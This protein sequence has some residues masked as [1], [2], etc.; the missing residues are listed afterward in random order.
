M[1]RRQYYRPLGL[2]LLVVQIWMASAAAACHNHAD[3]ERSPGAAGA[4]LSAPFPGASLS[5]AHTAPPCAACTYLKAVRGA[6]TVPAFVPAL[7]SGIA[8]V[9]PSAGQRVLYFEAFH[10]FIPNAQTFVTLDQ[11]VTDRWGLPAAVI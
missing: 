5:A 2:L 4:V 11:T 3:F 8:P 6:V 7:P 9:A 1:N 10:D